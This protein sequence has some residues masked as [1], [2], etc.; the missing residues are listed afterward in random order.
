M[1]TSFGYGRNG[2]AEIWSHLRYNLVLTAAQL[3]T[4]K[5]QLEAV[6]QW[7]VFFGE[8]HGVAFSEV[9][10]HLGSLIVALI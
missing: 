5:L 1:D 6:E 8:L 7:A 3:G 9:F 10:H 2:H 4:I